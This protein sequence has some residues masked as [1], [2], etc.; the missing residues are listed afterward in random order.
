MSEAPVPGLVSVPR[1][2][3]PL[4]IPRGSS[5]TN[6]SEKRGCSDKS[7]TLDDS[8]ES[9]ESA[10][11]GEE[12]CGREWEEREGAPRSLAKVGFIHTNTHTHSCTYM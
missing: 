12:A 6:L 4:S 3:P 10:D 8:E 5:T 1:P 11:E 2:R 9:D 7:L